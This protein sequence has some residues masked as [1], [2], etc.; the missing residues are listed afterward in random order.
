M[1]FKQFFWM[2]MTRLCLVL[3]ALAA[4]LWL[5]IHPGYHAAT[6]LLL[7][8]A[9]IAFV[10][11]Y[12]LVARTNAELARFLDA[13][14]Y[15]DFGQRFD[16]GG[17]G[18]G[19]GGLGETFT[20]I[21]AEHRDERSAQEARQRHLKVMIEHVPVP[22]ISLHGDGT[23]TSWNNA[24]RRLFGNITVTRAADLRQFG[25]AFLDTLEKARPGER[26]LAVFHVDGMERQLT[27]ATTQV[28]VAGKTEKLVSLQDIQSEL[29]GAQLAAWQDLVRVLTHEIMNSITPVA[30][31]ART[32]V[33]LVDEA[34]DK[35]TDAPAIHDDLTDVRDAVATVARRSDGLMQFVSGYRR[36]T[37]LPP[38][39][40]VRI[41]LDDL[42]A[43]VGRLARDDLRD[44]RIAFVT[45]VQPLGLELMADRGMME[46]VLLNLVQNAAQAMVPT[47]T[48]P[49]TDAL[50]AEDT[51]TDLS[52]A[53]RAAGDR[54]AANAAETKDQGEIHLAGCLNRRG[55]VV[56]TVADTGPGVPED[57]AAKIFVPFFTT[58]R[59]GSG[60]G[61][62][63]T[64]Q[65]MIAHGG[66]VRLSRRGDMDPTE[67]IPAGHT[68]AVFTLTF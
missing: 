48:R 27:V 46:Q 40:R 58:R 17:L 22:L 9:S 13:M 5:L 65:V 6:F 35:V 37:R 21:L 10:S 19:F 8:V 54:S 64:R 62:A 28:T 26:A 20:A 63:L 33:D 16:M 42:F 38:P 47:P 41:R 2:V 51:R 61:L 24:A 45:V 30:S 66:S 4:F 52:Q 60:V 31:L 68:G 32:A 39:D 11:L 36:L 44:R 15:G 25:A 1:D 67:L 43:A 49:R 56:I 12:R 18:A 7:S 53:Q 14:R 3:A 59:D 29:D 50:Q 23:V 34:R 55:H 57:I